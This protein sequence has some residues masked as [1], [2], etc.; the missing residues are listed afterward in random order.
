MSRDSP[1]E[2]A[3][4]AV[5]ADDHGIV[6]AATRQILAELG[7]IEIV[8]EAED[9]LAAIAAIR[10]H[11]PDL[12]VLDAAMPLAR[13]IEVFAE[14]RRWSPNT[15]VALLTGF[16][17]VGVLSDWLN[18]G[19][20]G[21]LLKSSPPEEMRRCFQ[22]LLAG[23]R[24]VASD[25]S[26]ILEGAAPR[27]DL[28]PREREVLALIASGHANVGIGKRLSISPKTVEKHRASLMMKLDVHSI[29]ELLVYALKEGLLDEHRQL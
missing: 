27:P 11:E 8:E 26:E 23:S 29:A 22:A 7:N 19:V 9:G 21:L 18:A 6:R 4:T 5:L 3:A 28:T 24:F 12:L 1:S 10:T 15:R 25:V 2:E 17:S 13:G 16:T 14:V 20:D